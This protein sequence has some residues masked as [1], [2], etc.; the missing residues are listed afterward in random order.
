MKKKTHEEFLEELKLKNDQYKNKEIEIVSEYKCSQCLIQVKTK[1]GLCLSLPNN[2]LKNKCITIESAINKTEY[3]KNICINKF[4]NDNDDLSEIEYVRSNI[5][6]KVKCGVSKEYYYITPNSYLNGGRSRKRSN[7][8]ISSDRRLDQKFVFD[9][10]KES[11]PDLELLSGQAYINNNT[12]LLLKSK[13]GVV[14]VK[15]HYLFNLYTPTINVSIDK[16]EYFINQAKEIHGDKYNY[17][18]VKYI[19]AH[20]KVKIISEYGVF[21]QTPNAHLQG[22]G[23]RIEYT[24]SQRESPPVW[25]YSTWQAAAEK[26]QNFTGYKVYIIE[27]WTEQNDERFFKI[28]RTFVELNRRFKA[29]KDMPYS[30]KVL[31]VIESESARE[32]CELEQEYK[33]RHKEY[34]YVPTKKF[35]GMHE[36]FSKLLTF[37]NRADDNKI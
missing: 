2:L 10:I 32:I 23:S 20:T 5:K 11:N 14:S 12:N 34:K 22:K 3:F 30:Y 19:D 26:S 21:E 4:G 36:C 37:K 8:R 35:G 15:P 25:N 13:Y 17:D 24:E 6:M 9:K 16:T 28:G 31:N 27:C 33:N 7:S 29:K 1:F 18:L